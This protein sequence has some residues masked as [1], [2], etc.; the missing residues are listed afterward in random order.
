M[1]FIV[2]MP[3]IPTSSE[4]TEPGKW[5]SATRGPTVTARDSSR[6][7][8]E[9]RGQS[10]EFIIEEHPV[11][12]IRPIK[13]GVIGAGISGITAGALLPTKVPGLDLRIYDKNSGLV[14]F[15]I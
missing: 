11:D 14:R 8:P 15:L 2:A 5:P 13:V 9:S 4:A 12:A 7:A 1:A 10:T 6:L 3:S